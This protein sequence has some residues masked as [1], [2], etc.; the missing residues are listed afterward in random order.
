[1]NG[2]SKFTAHAIMYADVQTDSS[3]MCLLSQ[4]DDA[5]GNALYIERANFDFNGIEVWLPAQPSDAASIRAVGHVPVRADAFQQRAYAIDVVYDGTQNDPDPTRQNQKRLKIYVDGM[6]DAA[7]T[8]VGVVPPQVAT[9]AAPF[10]VGMRNGQLPFRGPLWNVAVAAGYAASAQEV[11]L[12]A[13][14]QANGNPKYWS[15]PENPS[16]IPW[17]VFY[18]LDEVSDGSAPV[19]RVDAVSGRN[20]TDA[21]NVPSFG[22]AEWDDRSGNGNLALSTYTSAASQWAPPK[23]VAGPA[24]M[25]VWD[26]GA[27]HN[28]ATNFQCLNILPFNPQEYTVVSVF[29]LTDGHPHVNLWGAEVSGGLDGN[30]NSPR[31]CLSLNGDDF[32]SL[33]GSG[34]LGIFNNGYGDGSNS[35]AGYTDPGVRTDGQWTDVIQRYTTGDNR[36]RLWQNGTE[37]TVHPLI[38][39]PGFPF[40]EVTSIPANVPFPGFRIGCLGQWWLGD[41]NFRGLA[42]DLM[43]FKQAVADATI[44]SIHQWAAGRK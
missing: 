16:G 21:G 25:T 14:V 23:L 33:L 38:D 34:S 24:G 9:S 29:N 5:G 22:F 2:I 11:A 15:Y 13:N 40:A 43:I 32:S 28:V 12:A 6:L 35:A 30:N 3:E 44:S 31:A 42:S 8:Y 20:L 41:N 27:G 19:A 1:M 17:T 37:L 7:A 26:F 39:Q 36:E 4:W 10:T 18:A